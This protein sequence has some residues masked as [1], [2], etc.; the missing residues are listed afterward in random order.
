MKGKK[1]VLVMG[2]LLLATL[3]CGPRQGIA[4]SQSNGKSAESAVAKPPR[5]VMRGTTNVHRWNAAARHAD[6]RAAAIRKNHGAPTVQGE[7]N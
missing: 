5:G 1:C 4:Q 7:V 2:A 6:R 3:L